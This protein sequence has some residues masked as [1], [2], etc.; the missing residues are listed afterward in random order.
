MRKAAIAFAVSLVL[1]LGALGL[2]P[3][4]IDLDR[5]RPQ[6]AERL[7]EMLGR[8]VTLSGAID[9]SLLPNPHV[10]ARDVRIAGPLGAEAGEVMRVRE[11]DA[12]L[13]LWPLILGRLDVTSAKLVQPML[14]VDMAGGG[15]GG[16]RASVHSGGAG[17]VQ[18]AGGEM[19]LGSRSSVQIAE[20]TIEGGTVVFRRAG[21]QE[22][23][24]HVNMQVSGDVVSGPLRGRGSFTAQGAT[25]SVNAEIGRFDQQRVPISINFESATVG[26]ASV[27]GAIIPASDGAK[28]QGKLTLASADF[29]ALAALAGIG[30]VPPMLK[31]PLHL[32]G[33]IAA[34]THAVSFE[35][36]AFD[37][38][39]IHGGGT[40]KATAGLPLAL[41]ISFRVNAFDLDRFLAERAAVVGPAAGKA[42]ERDGVPLPRDLVT[43]SGLRFS[44]PPDVSA[45][46][47]LTV[48][49]MLWRHGVVRQV[50]FDANLED[51]K[52]VL[53]RAGAQLPGGS[54]A[55]ISG[56][57]ETIAGLPRFSGTVEASADNLRD[58]LRWGGVNVAGV[59]QDRLRRATF[60]TTL[61]AEDTTIEARSI[62]ISVDAARITGAA[63]I[64]LRNRVAV[65]ARLAI[66]Q[67][68]LDAYFNDSAAAPAAEAGS[69]GDSKED[70]RPGVRITVPGVFSQALMNIDANLDAGVD[71]LIWRNQAIGGIRFIGTLQNRDLTIRELSVGDLGG[72]TGKLSGYVQAIGSDDPQTEV[73]LDLHGPEF[74]RVL[75]L[76]APRAATADT[77]GEFTLG[78]EI[79]R[80]LGR[81]T[82]DGDLDA[83][84]GKLHVTGR[85]PQP[86]TWD[87]TVSLQ[88]PSFNRLVRLALPSY[89]PQGGEL[90]AV[91]FQ[92]GL[93]WAPKRV[94]LHG[95]D[96]KIADMT[97][98][99]D[100]SVALGERPALSGELLLGDLALDRFLPARVTVMLDPGELRGGGAG[101]MVAQAG[102]GVPRISVE[103]WS[104]TPFDLSFL[105]L[106]DAQ[107][108]VGGSSLAWGRWRLRTPHAKL[109]LKDAVLDATEVSGQIFGGALAAT[110]TVNATEIPSLELTMKLGQAEFARLLSSSGASRVQGKLDLQTT[111]RT[112][113]GSPA[114]FVAHLN[115]T[116]EI[117]GGD[118]SIEGINLPA[119]NQRIGAIKGLGDLGGLLRAGASGSTSFSSLDANFIVKD[120]IARSDNVH[121]VADGGEGIGT[122]A[123]DLPNWTL[124]SRNEIRL[125]GI[126]GAPPLGLT[127]AGPL[128]EP[129][130]SIDLGA[131][132]K[133]LADRLLDHAL[134]SGADQGGAQGSA[135]SDAGD[136]SG[137]VKTRDILRG[138]LKNTDPN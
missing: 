18:S 14:T 34:D 47:D 87:M 117:H 137:R 108:S 96:L 80:E 79:K 136:T 61:E 55:A 23:V 56:T 83:M 110:A 134:Q 120:G 49:A 39:D 91:Q 131:L 24:E 45:H 85:A 112:T 36:L 29:A 31:Q 99:G 50:R 73:A 82:I 98:G 65:G 27:S 104:R 71:T 89:R 122:L 95:I 63:T 78:L 124:T 57:I 93:A 115:G 119:I 94:E 75:R 118:G 105:R 68:N 11:I 128:D 133:M 81:V 48:D 54:D 126:S 59:P 88:H 26:T 86:D 46:V 7:S 111:L 19:A 1:V 30:P 33:E 41:G 10:A 44:F 109:V 58:L 21:L 74:A 20:I 4:M 67:L 25:L 77:F 66:D 60:A 43:A 103:R 116:A 40:M 70:A 123:L 107:V 16:T 17:P 2:G 37:L 69:A 42:Q 106:L 12:Q 5:Y 92:A 121:L 76:A 3:R 35:R 6:V 129:N 52:L 97:L 13:A 113:G 38:G 125:T 101:V 53:N 90:G 62:D 22:A 9:L 8:E 84:G 64:A 15:T 138:L 28:L 72:A 102:S 135:G 127:L 114:D 32:S 100:L 130:W 132:S 51:G